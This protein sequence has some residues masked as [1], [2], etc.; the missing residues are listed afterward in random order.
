MAGVRVAQVHGH[1][2]D[3]GRRVWP[4][5]RRTLAVVAMVLGKTDGI[6]AASIVADI[7]ASEVQSVASLVCGAV[8]ID[9]AT[10]RGAA[11]DRV[12]GVACK[13]TWRAL[14]LRGV[15]VGNAHG[16]G[17]AASG[18]AHRHTL[19]NI[20]SRLT[21]LGLRALSI[22]LALVTGQGTAPAAVVGVAREAS[23]A[24][25]LTTVVDGEAGGVERAVEVLAD[26]HA[27]EDAQLVGPT[28][29]RERALAVVL[30][31]GNVGLC[32]ETERMLVWLHRCHVTLA[33]YH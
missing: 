20:A 25:A 14:A 23:V 7:K 27:L 28:S 22:G 3:L 30:A 17:P 1:A 2:L 10:D 9:D 32:G 4:R 29:I 15:V 24:L 19:A 8:L 16:V 21:L 26:A 6:V 12:I 11:L 18:F 33:V 13:Q 31:V 5:A